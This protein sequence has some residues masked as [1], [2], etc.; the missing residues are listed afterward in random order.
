MKGCLTS[1][2]AHIYMGEDIKKARKKRES[3]VCL[4]INVPICVRLYM[5][6]IY[7][8]VEK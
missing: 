2:P 4:C 3:V 5:T 7:V 1:H 8:Y 6:F